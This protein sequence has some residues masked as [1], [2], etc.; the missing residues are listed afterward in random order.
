MPIGSILLGLAMAILVVP[1]VARP[2]VKDGQRKHTSPDGRGGPTPELTKHDALVALRDVD[3][4]FRT[5]KILAEDYT[6]LRARL[7]AEAAQAQQ[8][9]DAV[10]ALQPDWEAEIEAAVR[11]VR[12]K[13]APG[14]GAR[15]APATCPECQAPAREADKFCAQCG[16]ALNPTCPQCHG[17]VQISDKF[18]GR[19]GALAKVE[20]VPVS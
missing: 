1:F 19:C 5:G 10:A 12:G 14:V 8:A 4:D 3:F 6:P 7:L 18:C 16:A 13:K 15:L 2:F 11:A 9:E 17:V 20:V